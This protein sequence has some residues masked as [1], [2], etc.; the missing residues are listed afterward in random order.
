[1]S[2]YHDSSNVRGLHIRHLL[3]V[4]AVLGL[5]GGTVGPR[6]L[7][8]QDRDSTARASRPE[9]NPADVESPEAIVEAAYDVI[10]AP[11]G[12]KR[13]LDRMRSLFLPEAR[14]IPTSREE[15]SPAI[16]VST[17]DEYIENVDWE[18][19]RKRGFFERG[20]DTEVDRFGDIAHVLS[21]YGS[22]ESAKAEEPFER[23][24]NSFQLWNDGD[25]WWIVTIFWHPERDGAPIPKRYLD[26]DTE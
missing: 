6:S 9:A 26:G 18:A 5:V 12:E 24:V 14:L 22:Y 3:V 20:L 13:D 19:L 2:T 25:R 11:A 15:G 8:A 21:T 10:S 16:Q 1:M 17:V 23:G 4:C 7:H